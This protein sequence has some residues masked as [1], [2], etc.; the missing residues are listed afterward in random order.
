MRAAPVPSTPP[1][2]RVPDSNVVAAADVRAAGAAL[3]SIALHA[4]AVKSNT[5]P[6]ESGATAP[7][8]PL[9]RV[10]PHTNSLPPAAHTLANLR[11]ESVAV[12]AAIGIHVLL[13]GS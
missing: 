13:A 8:G 2:T 1:H 3:V 11:A 4:P 5:S 7:E 9:H 6:V 12:L 10:P